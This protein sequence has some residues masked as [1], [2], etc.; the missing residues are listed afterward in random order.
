MAHMV[1][2]IYIYISPS[3][4]EP[5]L[6]TIGRMTLTLIQYNSFTVPIINPKLLT[7]MYENCMYY[8]LII[9]CFKIRNN[10]TAYTIDISTH[11]YIEICTSYAPILSTLLDDKQVD[12]DKRRHELILRRQQPI[13][14]FTQVCTT[15]DRTQLSQPERNDPAEAASQHKHFHQPSR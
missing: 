5:S 13:A 9:R 12:L 1:H 7:R 6:T 11:E 10:K 8:F 3:N 14:L 15:V 4:Y 2:Y